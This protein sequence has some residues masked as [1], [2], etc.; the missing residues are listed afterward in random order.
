MPSSLSILSRILAL[1]LAATFLTACAT[2][3]E[4]IQDIQT[5]A[6]LAILEERLP[7]AI[8]TLRDG[9]AKYADSNE[10]R[11]ALSRALQSN[12][13]TQEAIDLLQAAVK[14]EPNADQLWVKIGELNVQL[15]KSEEAIAAF[16]AYLKNNGNDFLAWKAVALEQEKLGRL[17]QAIK[18][19]GR[20]NEL[21]PSSQPALKLGNLYLLSRNIPQARSW[22]GQA[23]AYGDDFASKEALAELIKLETDLK[24]FQQAS[25]WL[26]EYAKRYDDLSDPRV[27]ESQNVI[28]NWIRAREEIARQAQEMEKERRALEEQRLAAEKAAA[29][30]RLA[31]EESLAANEAQA[32]EAAEAAQNASTE[33]DSSEVAAN[34]KAPEP[35]FTEDESVAEVA[36]APVETSRYEQAIAAYESG[37]FATAIPLFWEQL[38]VSSEDPELWYRLSLAYF[39]QKS[40]LDAEATILEAKRRAP[41]SETI[42]FQY[43]RTIVNT[44]ST[45]RVLEEMKALRMLFP[46]SPSIALI[47]AQ[48]LRTANAPQAVTAA[49]YRDFLAIANRSTPGYQEAN[50]FLQ[51]GN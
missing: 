21:T 40:W 32:A 33:T 42:A 7:D 27:A 28:N 17:T 47:L 10:L 8:Q 39:S 12:G 19:A 29:D 26:D 9:L 24:Q 30:Q 31:L 44:Q 18:A 1:A 51:T 43:L 4:R 41:R 15:D 2:R 50:Q 46:R 22:F 36:P 48:T 25:V 5:E 23:A 6:N 38:G 35:L 49:A 45:T 37:D 3:E 13:Q 16:E 11:I 14:Q 20:W 34:E